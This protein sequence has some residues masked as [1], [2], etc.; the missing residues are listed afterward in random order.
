ME[1]MRKLHE[2]VKERSEKQQ[3]LELK[4]KTFEGE[5]YVLNIEIE[6]LKRLENVA[7]AGLDLQ[8]VQAAEAVL[9]VTGDP[10]GGADSSFGSPTIAELAIVDIATGCKHLK[11]EYYG[12]K[13]YESYYQRSNHPYGYGPRH[14][15]IVDEIAL[16]HPDVELSDEEKDA[17][18]YYLKNYAEV[19]KAQTKLILG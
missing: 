9:S 4:R 16:K 7:Q 17:C 5:S 18:I 6:E 13:R 3:E 19:K 8:K 1:K 2:I 11:A 10:Y 15:S 14:G 12:N